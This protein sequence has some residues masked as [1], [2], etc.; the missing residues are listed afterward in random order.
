[1]ARGNAPTNVPCVRNEN[2]FLRYSA[3]PRFEFLKLNVGGVLLV[4]AHA[5]HY[6]LAADLPVTYRPE[7]TIWLCP[8]MARNRPLIGERPRLP[9]YL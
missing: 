5:K 6:R 7:T 3:A 9:D 1:M 4:R 8:L 2:Y